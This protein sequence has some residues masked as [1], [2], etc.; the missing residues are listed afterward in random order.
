MIED[1]SAMKPVGRG[2]YEDAEGNMHVSVEEW[3]TILE[4]PDNPA[5]RDLVC[6]QAVAAARDVFPS[7]P[8][9]VE[10]NSLKWFSGSPDAGSPDCVCSVCGDVIRA[11]VPVRLF[12][13]GT[14]LEARFCPPCAYR[15]LGVAMAG[16]PESDLGQ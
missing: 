6:E 16:P 3:L 8:V 11:E 12:D 15:T 14:G 1:F 13:S 10:D 9:T 4:L 2:L 7:V 5:N